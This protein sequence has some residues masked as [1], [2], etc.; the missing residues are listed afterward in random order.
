MFMVVPVR[1]YVADNKLYFKNFAYT[2]SNLWEVAENIENLQV[3]FAA[4]EREVNIYLLARTS[5]PDPEYLDTNV[6]QLG[7]SSVGPFNDH[8]HRKVSE[9]RVM[10]RSMQ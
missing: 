10:V 2:S 3:E 9:A 5:D 1:I 7:N 8:I 6:Y 4:D